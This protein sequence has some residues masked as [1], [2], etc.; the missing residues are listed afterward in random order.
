LRLIR[1]AESLSMR[2][3]LTSALVL[4]LTTAACAPFPEVAAQ[5][6][7][8]GPYPS[9]QPIEEL[10]AQADVPSDPRAPAP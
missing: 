8:T 6:P 7:D 4:V 1:C 9:L 5:A 3:H 2:L 10:L